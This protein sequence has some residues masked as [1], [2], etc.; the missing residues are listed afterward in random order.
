MNID[1]RS[2]SIRGFKHILAPLVL[3]LIAAAFIYG[4][5]AFALPEKL[6]P[7]E[8]LFLIFSTFLTLL[9]LAA[10]VPCTAFSCYCAVAAIVKDKKYILPVV[11]FILDLG[12]LF[13]WVQAL[14]YFF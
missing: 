2:N 14:R 3:L 7:Y 8:T 12:V 10:T 1:P 11:S 6:L 5:T 13:V 4:S 9:F